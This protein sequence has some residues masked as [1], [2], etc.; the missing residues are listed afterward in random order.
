VKQKKPLG[1]PI[2]WVDRELDRLSRVTPD[3][4]QS[5]LVAWQANAPDEFD[6][7]PLAPQD[8]GKDTT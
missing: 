7:L 3:D 2:V 6:D 8:D 4:M 5:A 1:K